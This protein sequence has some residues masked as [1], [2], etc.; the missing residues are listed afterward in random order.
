MPGVYR[1]VGLLLAPRQTIWKNENVMHAYARTTSL[2]PPRKLSE[3]RCG[4]PTHE[5]FTAAAAGG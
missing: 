5:A 3:Q 2:V 1:S 4:L